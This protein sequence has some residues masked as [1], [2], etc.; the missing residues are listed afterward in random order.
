MAVI[1]NDQLPLEV[2]SKMLWRESNREGIPEKIKSGRY[3]VSKSIKKHI[4]MIP[5]L[6]RWRRSRAAARRMRSKH[7]Y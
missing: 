3:Y 7:S 1:V 2:A 4:K 6:K 5:H